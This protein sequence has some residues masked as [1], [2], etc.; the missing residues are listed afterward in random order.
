MAGRGPVDYAQRLDGV[1]ARVVHHL[2]LDA[3]FQQTVQ[4]AI[5]VDGDLLGAVLR[6]LL[7]CLRVGIRRQAGVQRFECSA[8]TARHDDLV[9]AH[10]AFGAEVAKSFA[11]QVFDRPAQPGQQIHRGLLHQHQLAITGGDFTN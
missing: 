2:D 7:H 11:V 8:Q 10:A 1:R 6:E 3:V 5:R 4:L 9:L